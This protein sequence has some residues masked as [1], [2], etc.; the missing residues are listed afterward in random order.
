MHI[1]LMV[2]L[3]ILAAIVLL[4]LLLLFLPAVLLIEY[5]NDSIT[6]K[7]RVLFLTVKLYPR[8]E[9]PSKKPKQPANE[10]KQPSEPQ[11][12][13]KPDIT[14]DKLAGIVKTAKGAVKIMF[15]HTKI[16]VTKLVWPVYD[17]NAADTAIAYGKLQ[18]YVGGALGV[19]QQFFD[20]SFKSA[21][22]FA[23]YDNIHEK[24]RCIYCKI[25]ATPFIMISTAFYVYTRLKRDKLI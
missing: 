3:C 10:E 23:D 25:G 19:L 1:F 15:S 22:I 20:I 16:A 8:Q 14:L 9:K 17:G 13:T 7:A 18:A 2:L 12:K 6:A 5:K 21:D 11:K 4:L 24:E